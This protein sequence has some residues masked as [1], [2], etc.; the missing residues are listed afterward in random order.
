MRNKNLSVILAL[1]LALTMVF[2]FTACGGGTDNSQEPSG[3]TPSE[4]QEGP[5]TPAALTEDDWALADEGAPV[6]CDFGL[7]DAGTDWTM[8]GAL[9]KLDYSDLANQGETLETR[10][11][12]A[13][14]KSGLTGFDF[15]T[16]FA[17]EE[18]TKEEAE[19]FGIDV[20]DILYT[21]CMEDESMDN[22]F[23][24]TGAY[25]NP[26]EGNY[27]QY[28]VYSTESYE[29][30]KDADVKSISEIMTKAFGVSAD[31]KLIA[32][33]F[34]AAY[35]RAAN[36]EPPEELQAGEDAEEIDPE[37]LELSGED[38][39]DDS[40]AEEEAETDEEDADTEEFSEEDLD[41]DE[42]MEDGDDFAC[43]LQQTIEIKG[44]GYTDRVIF[45]ISAQ[46]VDKE[47]V[48]GGAI[49][50]ASIERNRLYD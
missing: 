13:L 18:V 8:S 39:A 50:Y 29:K 17:S 42:L 7:T 27:Y 47:E 33:G 45:S 25:I 30:A 28:S 26:M 48:K 12:E 24:E 22:R 19:E 10:T 16:D 3:D 5:H 20:G 38:I 2:C 4:T 11:K 46:Q 44:D 21:S 36:Y 49:V 40:E 35:D 15:Y 32:E 9:E 6:V 34:K 37:E 23:V 1:M 41:L 31:E 43:A 14:E